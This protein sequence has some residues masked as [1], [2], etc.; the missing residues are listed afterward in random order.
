MEKQTSP[1]LDIELYQKLIQRNNKSIETSKKWLKANPEKARINNQN[2]Y[3]RLKENNP[4]KYLQLLQKKR[5][6]Y[7]ENKK[8]RN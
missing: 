6:Y 1:E 4:E 2:S 7:I 8:N 3:Q 5:K